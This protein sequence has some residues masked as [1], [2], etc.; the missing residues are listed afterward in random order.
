MASAQPRL[1]IVD[2]FPA[3]RDILARRFGRHGFETVEADCGQKALELVAQQRFD[4]VL[5]DVVM[6]DLDG[7]EVLRRIRSR[8]SAV[9]LP[10]IMVTGKS[11]GQDIVKA[12][13]L[14]ANDYVTKPVDFSVALARSGTQIARAK[15]EQAIRLAN[16]E[17]QRANAELERRIA[18]RT[19]ELA[20]A[21]HERARGGP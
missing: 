1:L 8:H 19:A 13:E 17:L 7:F 21:E 18:E 16:E 5:L 4:L 12:L 11:D 15:A 10:V 9:D 20:R 6:P 3:N 2:D 14:G